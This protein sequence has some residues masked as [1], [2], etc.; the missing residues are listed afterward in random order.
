MDDP[1][2]QE[3]LAMDAEDQ[4]VRDELARAGS[5]FH[6]YHPRMEEVH[7]RNAARLRQVI[8]AHGWPGRTLVGEDGAFAA[9][10]ILQH[11]IGE[12]PFMRGTLPLLWEAARAGEIPA[13]HAAFLEDRV[14]MY[15]GRPQLYG[16]QFFPGEDGAPQPHEI[17]EP[18][19][20]DRRRAEVG[21]EPFSQRLAAMRAQA[22]AEPKL[23]PAERVRFLRDYEDWLRRT[24][25]RA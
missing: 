4:R 25:W 18:A 19:D 13:W 7:R 17:A 22:A 12:P 24:G 8:A 21:L 2:R 5:L 15:E 1:L 3:L 14:R 23:A 10:R 11:S 16:T 20:L 6:G 9:W